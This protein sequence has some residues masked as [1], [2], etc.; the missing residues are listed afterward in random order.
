MKGVVDRIVENIAVVI[1]EDQG[2]VLNI[3][4]E[5]LPEGTHEGTWLT[6]GFSIDEGQTSDMYEK[7]KG[8]LER[9]IGRWKRFP[10]NAAR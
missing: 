7:N 8:L 2:V 9:L 3:P 1:I 4:I 5:D 6:V 10:K